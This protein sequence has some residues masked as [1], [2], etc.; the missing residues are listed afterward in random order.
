M[1]MKIPNLQWKWPNVEQKRKKPHEIRKIH[2]KINVRKKKQSV[3]NRIFWS[4]PD[5]QINWKS[6]TKLN[7]ADLNRYEVTAYTSFKLIRGNDVFEIFNV[8]CIKM[9]DEQIWKF[10]DGANWRL[11]C[12][13]MQYKCSQ[14]CVLIASGSLNALVI[15]KQHTV[16][17]IKNWI[18]RIEC[19]SNGEVHNQS[20]KNVVSKMQLHI[21]L[22]WIDAA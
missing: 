18:L 4:R 22:F 15:Y 6:T 14:T 12:L 8:V 1:A 7:D 20:A 9:L 16:D 5:L 21:L 2:I 13:H 11:A 10:V 3:A 17:E 19:I